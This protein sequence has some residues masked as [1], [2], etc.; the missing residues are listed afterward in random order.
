MPQYFVGI[1]VSKGRQEE[2]RDEETRK[3]GTVGVLKKGPMLH[4]R[5]VLGRVL[6]VYGQPRARALGPILGSRLFQHPHS[7]LLSPRC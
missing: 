2:T 4:E 7:H 1:D 5:P 3:L 6:N